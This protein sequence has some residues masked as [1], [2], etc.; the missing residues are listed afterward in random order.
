MAPARLRDGFTDVLAVEPVS[1]QVRIW[2]PNLRPQF[3][4]QWNFTLEYQL[5]NSTSLYSWLCSA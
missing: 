5:S 3:T 2:D 4:Q 1:G